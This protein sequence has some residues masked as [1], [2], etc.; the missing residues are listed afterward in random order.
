[1]T[2]FLG[3]LKVAKSHS[4]EHLHVGHFNETIDRMRRR[5]LAFTKLSAA[6][7]AG[8]D[9]GAA[10]ALAG[11]VW[12]ALGTAALAPAELLIMA[13]V[14]ARVTPALFRLQQLVQQLAHALPAY[15]NAREVGRVLRAAAEAPAGE[16]PMPMPLRRELAL[17]DVSFTHAPPGGRR[18]LC[19]VDLT[20]LPPGSWRSRVLPVPA[21][22]RSRISC[23]A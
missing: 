4:A 3:G 5:T 11:L 14:F 22:V 15:A 2:D 17:R 13:V 10:A 16:D 18:I 7:R 23:S 20:V 9:I 1:M 8:L 12:F 21:R 6:A 19:G